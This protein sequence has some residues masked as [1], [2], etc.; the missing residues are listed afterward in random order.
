MSP[1]SIVNRAKEIGLNALAL[2]DHN[3]TL[4]C[5]AFAEFCKR[6]GIYALFGTEVTTIEEGHVLCLFDYLDSAMQFGEMVYSRL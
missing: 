5:P 2:S 6:A 1:S 4:N 3:C